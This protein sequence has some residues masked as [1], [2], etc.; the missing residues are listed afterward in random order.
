MAS[1]YLT[2]DCFITHSGLL[3][4]M[5]LAVFLPFNINSTEECK[6]LY[7]TGIILHKLKCSEFQGII[8]TATGAA[9]ENQ[10]SAVHKDVIAQTFSRGVEGLGC[11][12][13]NL[14]HAFG[15]SLRTCILLVCAEPPLASSLPS[16]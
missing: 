3:S 14:S 12:P 10:V 2:L 7:M 11:S 1:K 8:S 5:N 16:L 13:F 6:A 9:W 4:L 15:V